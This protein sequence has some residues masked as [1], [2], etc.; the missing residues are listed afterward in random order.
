MIPVETAQALCLDLVT[1]TGAL[2]SVELAEAAG[3]V[4]RVAPVSRRA[5]PPFASSAMDGYALRSGDAGAG[6]SVEVVG[7]SAAGHSWDG[8][9]AAGQALRIFTGA[10]VPAGADCVVIQED[11]RRE[12][13]RLILTA[14][15]RPGDNIRPAGCDFPAGFA[16]SAPRRLSPADL[17]LLAAMNVP[18]VSVARRPR[19]LLLATG[20][21]L[22]MPGQEP[23]PDQIIASN[24]FALKAMID[25]AGGEGV[26]LPIAPD[27]EEALAEAMRSLA[28]GDIAVTIGGASVGD[29][30]LV[31]R[32]GEGLGMRRAFHKIA[33]RPG[34]PLIAGALG[35]VPY[36]GLPGNPVSAIVT[37][38]LFLL[39]MVRRWLGLQDVLP[40]TIPA[41]LACDIGANGPRT[42]Y[43]RARLEASV[44]TPFADQDSSL[45]SVLSQ[46]NA[47]LVR[48]LGDGPRK[49]GETVPVLAL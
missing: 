20:D 41:H 22:V 2:D 10:P 49:A 39:P 3:R 30:D 43:M 25:A 14:S 47:L 37:A 26:I 46:A 21:E 34:K 9:L 16:L 36:L 32:V 8:T 6:Q 19:V 35:A 40:R 17:A 38:H 11:T 4:V 23:G 5:Q 1:P 33:M 42:H 45:L 44:V 48:P 18:Q 12:G 31:G 13:S 15:A 29:H 7:E 28:H 27:R 24:T